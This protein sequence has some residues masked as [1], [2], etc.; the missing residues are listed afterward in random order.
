MSL[1][2][3]ARAI[4]LKNAYGLSGAQ[5]LAAME[6]GDD[7]PPRKLLLEMARAYR[8][9]LLVF[10]LSEPPRKGDRG[11]DFRT[12]QGQGQYTQELDALIRDIRSR[13]NLIRS[14]LEDGESE[15]VSFVGSASPATPPETLSALIA[16]RIQFSLGEF[17][18]QD[19]IEEAFAYLRRK[20]E[21]SGVFVLLLGNLG[22]HHTNIPA[23]TFRGFAVSDPVAPLVVINDQDARAA[24]SFTALHELAH[25]WLGATG[26]SGSDS[27]S[28]I[29]RYCNDV[30]SETLLP[31]LQLAAF[32]RAVSRHL[33]EAIAE[34]SEFSERCKL[35]RAMVSYGLFRGGFI[36]RDTWTDLNA[37]FREEWLLGKAKRAEKQR[38]AEGGPGYYVVRRYHVGAALL[39]L[40]R[41]SLGEGNTTYTKA[42]QVLGVK[43]GNVDPL[44]FPSSARG[45]GS[46]RDI[47]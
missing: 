39:D 5:R 1:E 8:R 16:Q 35:S 9:S 15:A 34:I 31:A 38:A 21:A 7:E 13:Q 30:A 18:A 22:S 32:G 3:G 47:E 36:D 33:K 20:I 25:L 27:D 37:H 23:E 10:Y 24:W 14:M 42:G 29:E 19:N 28:G 26:V 11:Q 12:I 6:M 44:L 41:R 4:G 40:V 43:P 46:A 17:Q 2:E 45:P